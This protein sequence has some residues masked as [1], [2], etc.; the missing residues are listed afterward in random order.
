MRSIGQSVQHYHL[1]TETDT[2]TNTD[3]CKTYTALAGAKIKNKFCD[4]ISDVKY[5][6]TKFSQQ[7]LV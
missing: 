7:C 4:L 1:E 5:S 2:N 6:V 3:M